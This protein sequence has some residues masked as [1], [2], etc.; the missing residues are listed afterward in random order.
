VGR[1]CC[2]RCH[3]IVVVLLKVEFM[4]ISWNKKMIGEE[5]DENKKMQLNTK[6]ES[7][8]IFLVL[9]VY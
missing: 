5:Y 1:R 4:S 6:D 2:C 9:K 3:V 7:K 8:M